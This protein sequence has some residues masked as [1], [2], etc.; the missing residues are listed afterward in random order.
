M[1]EEIAIEKL[2][3]R[4]HFTAV[5]PFYTHIRKDMQGAILRAT[6]AYKLWLCSLGESNPPFLLVSDPRGDLPKGEHCLTLRQLDFADLYAFFEKNGYPDPE[7]IK[8]M[9]RLFNARSQES[10]AREFFHEIMKGGH[11]FRTCSPLSDGYR[12]HLL[13]NMETLDHEIELF[14]S[15]GCRKDPRILFWARSRLVKASDNLADHWL[16]KFRGHALVIKNPKAG[17]SHLAQKLG[18][19][20]GY[21][22]AAS[23]RG[24][25]D[26]DGRVVHGLYHNLFG[27]LTLDEVSHYRDIVSDLALTFMEQGKQTVISAGVRIQ[28]VGAPS[29]SMILNAGCDMA[30]PRDMLEAIDRVLPQLTT[31]PEAFGSR[32]GL[33]IF[34]GTLLQTEQLTHVPQD[35]VEETALVVSA[36]FEVVVPQVRTIYR[37][38]RVQEWLNQTIAAYRDRILRLSQHFPEQFLF[39]KRCK[40]FWQDH[41]R[42]A[43]RHVR[44]VALEHALSRMVGELLSAPSSGPAVGVEAVE[45]VEPVRGV[46]VSEDL[47]SRV[48]DLADDAL[49]DVMAI[50]LESLKQMVEAT[51][52]SQDVLREIQVSQFDSL[53]PGY[54]KA[55]VFAYVLWVARKKPPPRQYATFT[56]LTIIYNDIDKSILR[57]Y[58]GNW[59]ENFGR[60]VD[61]FEKLTPAGRNE[62]ARTLGTRLGID[63]VYS[64]NEG[65]WLLRAVN[66]VS[67]LCTHVLDLLQQPG[68]DPSEPSTPSTAST[69]SPLENKVT[70]ETQVQSATRVDPIEKEADDHLGNYF[71]G[72]PAN[73]LIDESFAQV[74]KE[75]IKETIREVERTKTIATKPWREQIWWIRDNVRREVGEPMLHAYL[76]QAVPVTQLAAIV[77]EAK[78]MGLIFEISPGKFKIL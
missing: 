4:T 6:P 2:H 49:A 59:Y 68:G 38:P 78:K 31:V 7:T 62:V 8:H 24:Y 13:E 21:A 36:L 76:Q 46:G 33:I 35:T 9:A 70:Q 43:Y 30:T 37:H 40:I 61:G 14:L 28:N 64:G 73:S 11:F 69:G 58:V 74:E 72:R 75:R 56:D 18:L 3:P 27:S 23:I 77:E 53:R 54:L 52:A 39:G 63:L 45:P 57:E 15:E 16:E 41:A 22:S 12:A 48:L 60:V 50:N 32:F 44:G 65:M 42:G 66:D 67:P 5:R 20:A 19:C 47:I 71:G 17:F 26:G 51:S 10:D 29:I 34:S 25:A 55:M 1:G